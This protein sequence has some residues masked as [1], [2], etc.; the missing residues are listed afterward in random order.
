MSDN[1][2]ALVRRIYETGC[3][4]SGGDPGA[5]LEYLDEAFQFINPS[6]AVLSSPRYGH[7]GFLDAMRNPREAFEFWR[8]E[9]LS[10][11]GGGDHVL[12]DIMV[13]TRGELSEIEFKRPEWHVWTLRHGKAIRVAWL[14]DEAEARALAGLRV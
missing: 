14:E 1:C 11:H 5:A 7:Q 8:H 12:V 3:W 10:F 2:V 9:P 13:S 6:H 4:D